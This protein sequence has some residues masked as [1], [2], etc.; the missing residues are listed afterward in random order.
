[1][2]NAKLIII[3]I[4][5]IAVIGFAFNAFAHGGGMGWGGGRGHHGRGWHHM[6]DYDDQGY[7]DQMT[8]EQYKQLEQ[9][10]EA[11]F[12]D[13]QDLRASLYE[14]ERELQD[15]L[16]KEELDSAKASGLQK[17]ISEIRAQLDQKRLDHMIE[18]RK[19]APNAGRRFM[20]GGPMMGYG[21]RGGGNCW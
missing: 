6:G 1:M 17:E 20:R 16:S 19:L 21:P 13:T 5:S 15:E 2:R 3:T 11:F 8:K 9:K 14:K 18:M 4:V 7:P 10:R 12:K